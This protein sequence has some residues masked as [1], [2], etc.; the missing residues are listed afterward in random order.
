MIT[1]TRS[2][3]DVLKFLAQQGY[4]PPTGTWYNKIDEWRSWYKGKV[5][6]FHRYRQYNG[7]RWLDRSRQ[8]LGMAK[9]ICEDK[10]DLLLNERC[11]IN[12]SDDS[13]QDYLD[14]VL[15][16][17]AF[18]S[19]GNQLVELSAALGTGAF[20]EYLD[21]GC[22]KIDYVP[23]NMIF[24]LV[25]DNGVITECAFASLINLKSGEYTYIAMHVKD[26]DSGNYVIRNFVFDPKGNPVELPDGLEPEW[27]TQDTVPLFQIIKPAAVNNYDYHNP[28]G[29]SIF[30][31][32]I[33][34]LKGIDLVYDSYDNEFRLGKKRI[35]VRDSVVRVVPA[36]DGSGNVQQL[37]IFDDNDTEFYA[38]DL[39]EGEDSIKEVNMELRA[40]DHELALQ[41]HLDLLSEICGF[42]KGY[43]KADADATITA[44]G[45]ISQNSQ[46]YRR[47]RKDELVLDHALTGMVAA[48]F[49]LAAATG[50]PVPDPGE[51]DINFDD[52]IVEDTDAIAKRS[53]LE[54]QS[55]I[56]SGAEYL[57]RVYH[58]TLEKAMDLVNEAKATAPEPP[59][60]NPD[61]LF[62]DKNGGDQSGKMSGGQPSVDDTGG[63]A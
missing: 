54:V 35:F 1:T 53:L 18:W 14:A 27:N 5:E 49:F 36:T 4:N 16:D 17:N 40:A 59:N 57:Q 43:Y 55:E 46:L 6:H 11:S 51:T 34:V 52:S 7:F 3:V 13:A 41:R 2:G 22:I 9:K 48:V 8:T 56:I 32:A 30:A 42:G 25:W 62:P 58:L 63:G 44:T 12:V 28:M 45:V 24:P 50:A 23:A 37:P 39:A 31:N 21:G 61:N 10:A 26:P 33:D 38:V 60:P 47:I 19:R 29:I 15:E 20:V